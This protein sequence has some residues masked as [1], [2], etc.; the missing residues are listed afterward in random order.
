MTKMTKNDPF[1]LVRFSVFFDWHANVTYTLFFFYKKLAIRN[2]RL[3]WQ[4]N[5]K[6]QGWTR[7]D[8]RNCQIQ[9]IQNVELAK[10]IFQVLS[11]IY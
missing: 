6:L 5:K 8:L 1:P 9:K 11:S 2:R 7:T 4:K 10:V 3:R